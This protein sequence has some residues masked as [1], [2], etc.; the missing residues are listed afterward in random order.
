MFSCCP[1]VKVCLFEA[2]T[3]S[4]ELRLSQRSDAVQ[5]RPERSYQ[6]IDVINPVMLRQQQSSLRCLH[7]VLLHCSEDLVHKHK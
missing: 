2:T 4:T 3:I 6:A 1:P 5:S 7:S